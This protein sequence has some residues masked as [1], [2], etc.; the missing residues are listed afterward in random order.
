[1]QQDVI[2]IAHQAI[3][4]HLRV[5]APQA[6]YFIPSSTARSV[7]SSKIGSRRSPRELTW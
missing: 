7:S 2:V 3:G 6:S 4:Q 5:I 1:V